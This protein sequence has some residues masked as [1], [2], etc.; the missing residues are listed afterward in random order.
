METI[1]MLISHRDIAYKP[2]GS[3]AQFKVTVINQSD[4][5]ASFQLDITPAGVEQNQDRLWYSISPEVSTK[6][7]PGDAVEFTVSILDT[8][9]M[10]FVGLV[11]LTVRT[12]SLELRDEV[13]Q[14]IRLELQEGTGQ[15]RIQL[16]L[17]FQRLQV[18][19]LDMVEIPVLVRNPSQ[20][21]T[22]VTLACEGIPAN[23]LI[24]GATRQF[25]VKAGGQFSTAFLC[26]PPFSPEAISK[27]YGMTIR[28]KHTNGP[29]ATATAG[30][31]VLPRG[32]LAFDCQPRVQTVPN[33]FSWR[34]W[35]NSPAIYQLLLNNASNLEQTVSIDI[36]N[37]AEEE[38]TSELVPNEAKLLPLTQQSMSLR[39]SKN[40]PLLGGVQRLELQVK[41]L[42]QD[43][44][45]EARN[46]I[47]TIELRLKPII[48]SW[49]FILLLAIILGILWY[50]SW[51][52]PESPFIAHRAAVT[53]VQLDGLSATALSSSNDQTLRQ[54]RTV[55]F[56][57]PIF[58]RDM[59]VVAQGQKAMR[60]VRFRPVNNDMAA[61]GLE[62][63]EIQLWDLLEKKA[64]KTLI[65]YSFQRDDRVFGLAF[66]LDSRFLFSSHGSGQVL[67]W[68][69]DRHLIRQSSAK[70]QQPLQSQKLNFAISDSVLVGDNDNI[71][72]I[73]GRYNSLVLWNWEQNTVRPVAYPEIGGQDDY[74][75]SMDVPEFRR[76]LLA[77]A[78]TKGFIT[79]WDM[80]PCLKDTSQTCNIV[81]RWGDG[82]Q[83]K[84]VRSVGI[85]PNGC[86]LV[87]GG[88][89]GRLMF[90]G[91][92]A[93]GRRAGEFAN[94]KPLA[95]LNA[96]VTA[97]DVRVQQHQVIAIAGDSTGRVRGY[98][99]D[100]LPS[101]GCDR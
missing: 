41:S 54:W 72:A 89:D 59:G 90:W 64:D 37:E 39:I 71:L 91:L 30:L 52:N 8:P 70:L 58:N 68:S 23:W 78:D 95:V 35:Q 34:F 20:Q 10:G 84:P 81:D 73:A 83:G 69:V 6:N 5:F 33:K 60:V 31:E 16:E 40:R 53:S 13:R 94:G 87:S 9:I 101:L 65:S 2:G 18:A 96:N 12:F 55:G 51:L 4:R 76:N 63:G 67:R 62:N 49:A 27:V 85:D 48:P 42:W 21:A 32:S 97:V 99:Q 56:W 44:R 77:T 25:Q 93:A 43:R 7:P 66:T 15:S 19:P 29:E 74:I 11:N 80:T 17:P 24:E 47:Q 3:P 26:Q 100:R 88:D 36:L 79:V 98:R 14:V 45:L 86:Y 57:Q 38:Y 61:I 46:P 50:F 75:Q 22:N 92:T 28:A 82:H 1:A